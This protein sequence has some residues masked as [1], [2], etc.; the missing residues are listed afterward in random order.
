M[1][2]QRMEIGDLM[3]KQIKPARHVVSEVIPVGLTLLASRPKLGKSWMV[4]DLAISVASGRNFLDRVTLEGDVLYWALEDSEERLKTRAIQLVGDDEITHRLDIEA[5]GSQI[6]PD[7]AYEEMKDWIAEVENPRLI[8]IDTL[9]KIRK[10]RSGMGQGYDQDYDFGE[11]L[12]KLAHKKGIAIVLVYH[13]TKAVR[14]DFID[15]VQDTTGMTAVPDI[16]IVM[17]RKRG[18]A[19]A[20]LHMAPKDFNETTLRIK[21]NQETGRWDY[22]GEVDGEEKNNRPEVRQKVIEYLA[23]KETPQSPMQIAN[24]TKI[25]LVLLRTYLR[26]MVSYGELLN[27]AYG[28]YALTDSVREELGMPP[29]APAAPKGVNIRR[30]G[31]RK[32][33]KLLPRNK[34]TKRTDAA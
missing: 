8:I 17:R 28:Q 4:F 5:V 33:K 12:Q 9:K 6:T 18:Q 32:P 7:T 20:E 26:R 3:T 22:V 16:V 11:K 23:R 10:S 30:A 25:E 24:G 13:T 27:P 34:D 31:L 15:E 19:E 1:T 2:E 14:E 21:H 29:V